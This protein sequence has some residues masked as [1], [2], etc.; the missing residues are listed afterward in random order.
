MYVLCFMRMCKVWSA[1]LLDIII[2]FFKASCVS[3]SKIYPYFEQS[4]LKKYHSNTWDSALFCVFKYL[5]F[6]FL[7]P[8]PISTILC[9]A[10][11]SISSSPDQKCNS[12]YRTKLP[13]QISTK[14]LLHYFKV[15]LSSYRQIS[16][17]AIDSKLALNKLFLC[18]PF[19]VIASNDT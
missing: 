18:L 1:C 8:S 7:K 3:I 5:H 14:K 15:N 9:F 16:L 2:G 4:N 17:K 6:A 11:Q 13:L 19:F 12:L 10:I